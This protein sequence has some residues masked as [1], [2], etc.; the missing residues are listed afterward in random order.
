MNVEVDYYTHDTKA[1]L[2]KRAKEVDDHAIAN[3]NRSLYGELCWRIPQLGIL[4][5]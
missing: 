4:T 3:S 1:R 5:T 2:L